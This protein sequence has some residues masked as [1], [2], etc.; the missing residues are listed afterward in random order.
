L[1][2]NC[3]SD[4][5]ADHKR[6]VLRGR[7]HAFNWT[8]IKTGEELKRDWQYDKITETDTG[9]GQKNRECYYPEATSSTVAQAR[10]G[11]LYKAPDIIQKEW[12]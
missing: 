3:K 7:D 10:E 11:R 5:T 1:K 8:D 6:E 12:Q 9:C 4:D 2:D